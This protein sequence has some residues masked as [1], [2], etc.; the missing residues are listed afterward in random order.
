M[1]DIKA[2]RLPKFI[3]IWQI[4]KLL[5]VLSAMF[6]LP[7]IFHAIPVSSNLPI[8]AVWLPIFYAPL[9]AILC[10]KP[11]VA[12]FAA[13]SS[14]IINMLLTGRPSFDVAQTLSYELA[15]FVLVTNWLSG[16]KKKFWLAG[17]IAYLFSKFAVVILMQ[18][19]L[20]T[21]FQPIYHAIPGIIILLII[22][23]VVTHTKAAR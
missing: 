1:G 17:T 7:V 6:F 11:H 15:I 4:D 10:F 14:P 13:L 21:V 12:L 20:A 5:L 3:E 18:K 22:N 9:I 23:F 8:G 19:D 2:M 16:L